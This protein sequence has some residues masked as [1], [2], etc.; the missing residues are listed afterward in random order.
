MGNQALSADRIQQIIALRRQG[1]SMFEIAQEVGISKGAV[2]EN[3]KKYAT[4]GTQAQPLPTGAPPPK[5]GKSG[6]VVNRTDIDGSLEMIKMDRPPTVEEMM[7]ACALDPR[8]W[9]PQYFKGNAW[10]GFAKMKVPGEKGLE[11]I[12]KVPL[13]QSMITCKRVITEELEAAILGFVRG[14]VKPLPAPKRSLRPTGEDRRFLVCWGLWDT[15]LGMYA[16]Q[17][18]T[19]ASFDVSIARARILNS[20]DDMLAELRPYPIER[21][22]MP[23]G[24][25]FLHFDSVRHKTAFGEHFLDTDTRFAKV[26]MIGLECLSYMVERAREIAPKVEILYIPGNHDTT[27]SFTLCA[28]LQQRFRADPSVS[29]DLG[30]N[31]RK[32]VTHGGVLLGFDH[33]AEAKAKQLAMIFATEAKEHWSRSTYREVQVG[34]THQRAE[35]GFATVVPTNGVLVRTNPALCNNDMWHH[36]QGLIGEPVKSVEA[37]RYDKVGYRGSHVTWARDDARKS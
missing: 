6:T 35:E 23:V 19:G 1:K 3:L 32:Y 22:V 30:A 29:V 20:I 11:E 4:R 33:G 16:W 5:G 36:R 28:A 12:R 13:Y 14:N 8:V 17:S 31:P 37:W 25:D 34:H 9:I 26:Y 15:H 18:E 27:S 2:C 7:K 10:Q 24:N 21:L